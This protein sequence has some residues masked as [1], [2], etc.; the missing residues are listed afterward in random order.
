MEK[1]NQSNS[2]PNID[3][4]RTTNVM[5][6][7]SRS[8]TSNDEPRRSPTLLSL[9]RIRS[10]S[11]IRSPL[12]SRIQTRSPDPVPMV[13]PSVQSQVGDSLHMPRTALFLFR[14]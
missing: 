13:A 5:G 6:K 4:H 1:D 8:P 3:A 12:S 9:M 7:L 11:N 14:Q 2:D 10:P